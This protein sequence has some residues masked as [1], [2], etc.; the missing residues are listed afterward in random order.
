MKKK[1]FLNL[2]SKKIFLQEIT[3]PCNIRGAYF[4]SYDSKAPVTLIV[5]L[6]I[7]LIKL[8]IKIKIKSPR[9]RTLFI[10]EEKREGIFSLD[11]SEKGEY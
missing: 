8:K 5:I 6:I 2:F 11:L 9:K 3:K 4:V 10:R 7:K 1:K